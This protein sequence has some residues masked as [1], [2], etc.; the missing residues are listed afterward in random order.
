MIDER[1]GLPKDIDNASEG[2]LPPF[3]PAHFISLNRNSPILK[4]F[5]LE[6]DVEQKVYITLPYCFFGLDDLVA[7]CKEFH[8]RVVKL[9]GDKWDLEQEVKHLSLEVSIYSS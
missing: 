7:I 2:K 8:G 9:E 6:K 3:T 1:C 5:V 4:S